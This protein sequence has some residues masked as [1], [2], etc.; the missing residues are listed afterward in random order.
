MKLIQKLVSERFASSAAQFLK[1]ICYFVMAF[2]L[3]C[4]VLSCM[5][6]Q[7]FTL[8]A[9]TGTYDRAIYAE[10]DHSPRSRSSSH[11]I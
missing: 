8:H 7:T 3:L 9:S 5:G 11:S 4:L 1:I 10:E 6:R 2:F